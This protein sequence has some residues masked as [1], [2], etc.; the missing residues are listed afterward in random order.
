[1]LNARLIKL[2]ESAC[3]HRH[4]HHQLVIGVGG[5][6]E[7]CVDGIGSRVDSWTACLVPTDARHDYRGNERNHVL[8]VDLDPYFPALNNPAHS[9]YERLAPLFERPRN[10]G[11]DNR[12]QGLVQL[13]AGE[14]SRAPDNDTMHRHLATGILHCMSE[15][16]A[17]SDNPRHSRKTVCPDTIRR[18]VMENLHKK[19]TVRDLAS[20]ACLSVSRFHETFRAITG[21]T[22]HQYLLQTRL[23]QA[24]Q[25]LT[26]TALTVSEISFRTG[27]SSQGALTN[28]LHKHRGITPS[29]LRSTET[30]TLD[31]G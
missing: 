8:V 10:M 23:E 18:F 4:E 12:L 26:G 20:V 16:L 30:K 2:P 9:D 3:Q 1:M 19:I 17:T 28:A 21:I 24:V 22:P 5:E 11:M 15:R 13:C 27:F 6:S 14:F 25:L 31:F 29:V 7:V